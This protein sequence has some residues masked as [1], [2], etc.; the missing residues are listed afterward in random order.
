MPN[1]DVHVVSSLMKQYLRELPEPL[2]TFEMVTG[3]S[4]LVCQCLVLIG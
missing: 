3:L 1:T 2:L 4:P